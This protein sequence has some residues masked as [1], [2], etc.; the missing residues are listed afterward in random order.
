MLW[1][2]AGIYS[3]NLV[4]NK[5]VLFVTANLNAGG[6]QRSLVNLTSHLKDIDIA[7]C[8]YST[9]DYFYNVLK[10]KKIFIGKE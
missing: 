1:N 8:N 4:D 2:L 3:N 10:E 6:A 7:V 5:E 9:N